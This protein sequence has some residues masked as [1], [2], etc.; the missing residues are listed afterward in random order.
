MWK[1]DARAN[2]QYI[3]WK[4][5]DGTLRGPRYYALDQSIA[6]S[7]KDPTSNKTIPHGTSICDKYGNP[8]LNAVMSDQGM[9]VVEVSKTKVLPKIIKDNPGF[10]KCLK[11]N[12]HLFKRIIKNGMRERL[13]KVWSPSSNV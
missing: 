2:C 4:E 5:Q 10:A 9:P 1:P 3:E 13:Q 7:F 8:V 12:P 6:L 11:D